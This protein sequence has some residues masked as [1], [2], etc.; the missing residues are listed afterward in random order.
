MEEAPAL[1]RI[2]VGVDPPGTT[3][4]CGIVIAGAANIANKTHG[5]VLADR[6]MAGKP[7][8]WGTM[9]VN[10][11]NDFGADRI[12]GETNFGG[13]MVEN[14]IR[15]VPKGALVPYKSVRAS[16]GKQIRAEPI[17]SLYERG[18]IHHCGTFDHL[19]DQLTNW[20]PG[21]GKSPDRLDALVWALWYVMMSSR[22]WTRGIGA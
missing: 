14:T 1:F 17:A 6:S 20:V 22:G 8:K 11:Y 18:F 2:A 21:T 7:H 10:S 16:R 5:F 9:V 3:G 4:E 12:I 15:T 19:E 13:D